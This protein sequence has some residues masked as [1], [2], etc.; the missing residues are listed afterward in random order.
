LSSIRS[1]VLITL[2]HNVAVWREYTNIQ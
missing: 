1:N 2:V